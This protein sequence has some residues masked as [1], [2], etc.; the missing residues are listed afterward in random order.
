VA[1]MSVFGMWSKKPQPKPSA[2]DSFQTVQSSREKLEYA[3]EDI[4]K[5]MD[6]HKRKFLYHEENGQRPQ[7]NA[8]LLLFSGL[9]KQEL[10]LV[11]QIALLQQR[12][13]DTEELNRTKTVA[14]ITSD[15]ASARK[16][17]GAGITQKEV[18]EVADLFDEDVD[19]LADVQHGLSYNREEA[20]VDVDDLR[21]RM[22]GAKA[23]KKTTAPK[24]KTV[25]TS[26]E[27]VA[28]SSSSSSIDLSSPRRV[29]ETAT[30]T[31][32]RRPPPTTPPPTSEVKSNRKKLESLSLV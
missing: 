26:D 5:N 20:S 13:Y 10:R 30:A 14:E 31:P 21:E 28:S 6:K 1:A 2:M 12:I 22:L 9:E 11:N 19:V 3:L 32:S 25:S 4:R 27:R 8:E 7:A 29:M 24:Q 15:L 16:K 18:D 17:F 23:P